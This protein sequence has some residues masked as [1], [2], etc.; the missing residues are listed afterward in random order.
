[1]LFTSYTKQLLQAMNGN[2]GISKK[3]KGA[4]LTLRDAAYSSMPLE[5]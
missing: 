4:K 5:W 3:G 1:M 2:I